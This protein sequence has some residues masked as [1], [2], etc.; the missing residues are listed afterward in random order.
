M[1]STFIKNLNR[2]QWVS[3]AAYYKALA[4]GFEPHKE[5][6]DWLAA[7][8]DYL[9][10]LVELQL[11]VLEEDGTVS[12]MGLQQIAAS[13]G[14]ENSARM[15]SEFDLIQAIQEATHHRPCFQ[16]EGKTFCEEKDCLW[17]VKCR[18]LVAMWCR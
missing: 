2:Q 5:L 1:L 8:D 12:T 16:L 4:R 7:E 17:K 13:L 11:H 14:V 18:K 3:E 10:M 15:R 6:D 9:T